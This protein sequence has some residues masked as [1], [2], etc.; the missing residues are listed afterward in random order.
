MWKLGKNSIYSTSSYLNFGI[1]FPPTWHRDV[2]ILCMYV[3]P[4][5]LFDFVFLSICSLHCE[6]LSFSCSE[7]HIHEEVQKGFFAQN[8]SK[9][10]HLQLGTKML[11]H[12]TA[13]WID[14]L[15]SFIPCLSSAN[16]PTWSLF[17]TAATAT[18]AFVK[19]LVKLVV[20]M[21][22]NGRTDHVGKWA[23]QKKP[24]PFAFRLNLWTSPSQLQRINS[25]NDKV[26]PLSERCIKC[27]VAQQYLL[28][29]RRAMKS[30]FSRK[31]IMKM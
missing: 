26:G 22:Q 27:A 11:I 24:Q 2:G 29:H 6:R 20:L 4:C 5:K 25:N 16:L 10:S 19:W 7:M 28:R 15:W 9:K 18:I 1:Y 12:P 8:Q 17:L 13:S 3:W 30:L 23:S 31:K 14:T 21:H